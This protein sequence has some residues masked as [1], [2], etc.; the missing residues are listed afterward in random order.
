VSKLQ[1][2][3]KGIGCSGNKRSGR[4][5][6]VIHKGEIPGVQNAIGRIEVPR[7]AEREGERTLSQHTGLVWERISE[8]GG[9]E[10]TGKRVGK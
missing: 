1:A 7:G 10:E 3:R 4:Y 5:R 2:E 8:G 6:I 9:G